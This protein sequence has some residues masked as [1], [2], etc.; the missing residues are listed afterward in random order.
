M[1]TKLA[2][3]LRLARLIQEARRSGRHR[4]AREAV[5]AALAEYVKK[6][7]RLKILE[8]FGKVEFDSNYDYKAERDRKS[9]FKG[10]GADPSPSRSRKERPL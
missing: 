7:Q 1:L 6:L 5:E 9:R 2:I 10:G 4:S 3:D 8:Q